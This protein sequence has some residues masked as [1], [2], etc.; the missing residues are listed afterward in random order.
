MKIQQQYRKL[1]KEATDR[2]QDLGAA[3]AVLVDDAKR[4]MYDRCGEEC[5]K[6]DTMMNNLVPFASFHGGLFGDENRGSARETP[7]WCHYDFA[8]HIGGYFYHYVIV[9]CRAT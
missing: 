4:L 7:V 5:L 1:A 2:F 8:V 3:Y 6:K 9:H